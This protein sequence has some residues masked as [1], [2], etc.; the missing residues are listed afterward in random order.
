M[1]TRQI[2]AAAL[3]ASLLLAVV[4]APASADD[5]VPSNPLVSFSANNGPSIFTQPQ[6][7]TETSPLLTVRGAQVAR[8]LTLDPV[9]AKPVSTSPVNSSTFVAYS[10]LLDT[11]APLVEFRYRAVGGKYRLLV[12]W[13][14]PSSAQLIIDQNN[15]GLY[16]TRYTFPDRAMRHLELQI[17]STRFDQLSINTADLAVRSEPANTRAVILGDSYT[18]GTG[19]LA[20]FTTWAQAFCSDVGWDDCWASGSGG[21]GYLKPGPYSRVK[22]RNRVLHDLINYHPDHVMIAGGRNDVYTYTPAQVQTEAT[23][24]FKQIRAALPLAEI[25]VTSPLPATGTEAQASAV[26]AIG[27]ALKASA[28]TAGAVY[29]DVLGPNAYITGTGTVAAPNGTGNSDWLTGKDK[30]HPTQAGHDELAAQLFTR[31]NRI[32]FNDPG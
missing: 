24:L 5:P 11:D 16:R 28:Q 29:L 13:Q 7:L 8:N 23:A 21:T 17:D 22:F 6:I 20:R 14:D 30:V 9:A 3:T 32:L 1:T 15:G 10:V 31:Y 26:T 2:A 27:N 25:I 4:A 12:N 18:E 19:A